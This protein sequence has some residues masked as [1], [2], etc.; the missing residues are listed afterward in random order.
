MQDTLLQEK[1]KKRDREWLFVLA[2][3]IASTVFRFIIGNYFRNIHIYTDDQLYYQLAESFAQGRGFKVCNADRPYRILYPILIS[4]AFLFKD[5]HVQ[6]SVIQFINSAVI[7][8]A[9]FPFA[10][11]VR[12]VLENKRM[13][14]MAYIFFFLSAD[15]CYSMTFLSENLFLPMGM[16]VICITMLYVWNP[17][18][19]LAGDHI[20]AAVTGLLVYLTHM[21]KNAAILL[22]PI[23]IAMIFLDTVWGYIKEK[24]RKRALGRAADIVIILAVYVILKKIGEKTWLY[25]DPSLVYEEPPREL[26]VEYS[27]LPGNFI[28]L[29]VTAVIATGIL[30]ILMP[31][32]YYKKLNPR[33]K[34]LYVM[35]AIMFGGGMAALMWY[36]RGGVG[37]ELIR[38]HFR[39]VMYMW[40]TIQLCF[41]ALMEKKL[42]GK[43]IRNTIL[44]AVPVLICAVVF[45]GTFDGGTADQTLCYYIIRFFTERINLF[46]IMIAVVAVVSIPLMQKYQRQTFIAFMVFYTGIQ[47][48]NNA[49]IIKYHHQD[50]S[51]SEEEY[52]QIKPLEDLIEND[53]EHNYAVIMEGDL[54]NR[55]NRLMD[56]FLNKENVYEYYYSELIA[57]WSRRGTEPAFSNIENPY[58]VRYADLEKIDYILMR[59]DTRYSW[60]AEMMTAVEGYDSAYW[61]LYSVKSPESLPVF[62]E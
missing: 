19:D 2:V 24:D 3:Y 34:K 14:L 32:I 48:V 1:E 23:V 7:S 27:K 35:T 9:I 54:S 16:W 20:R 45:K 47:L 55:G 37:R 58:G 15:L 41:W 17:K 29:A 33:T 10:I 49:L 6:M 30:P 13:R 26:N 21:V 5:R 50:Y 46:R 8:S 40:L 22:I 51:L 52:G 11:M 36:N 31:L 53:K 42:E 4:P 56:T 44:F 59:T 39:Y 28:Y 18:H 12:K 60:D 25:I 57:T 38:P 43:V 62:S 61:K